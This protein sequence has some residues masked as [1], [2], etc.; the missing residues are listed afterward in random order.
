MKG[1]RKTIKNRNERR[2]E[3]KREEK[4]KRKGHVKDGHD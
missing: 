3:E 4:K 1:G 2:G